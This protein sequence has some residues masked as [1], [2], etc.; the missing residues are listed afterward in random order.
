M[1]SQ[2]VRFLE[3]NIQI[4]SVLRLFVLSQILY[5]PVCKNSY[6]LIST[7]HKPIWLSILHAFSQLNLIIT[8]LK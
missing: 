3:V 6:L 1:G 5:N 8:L 7:Y 4:K 2:K